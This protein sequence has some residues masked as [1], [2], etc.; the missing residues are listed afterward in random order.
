MNW[1]RLFNSYVPQRKCSDPLT[2]MA[3][4]ASVVNGISG[5]FSQGSANDTNV[6]LARES[7]EWQSKENQLNRDWQETM[8]NKQ[9]EY[10]TPANQRMLA[11]QGG[12]NPYLLSTKN[13]QSGAGAAGTPAAVGAPNV[14]HVNPINPVGVATDTMSSLLP[15]IQQHQQVESNVQLQ[16]SKEIQ[17]YVQTAIDAYDKLGY[18]GYI[19][20]MD[21]LAPALSQIN[22]TDSRSDIMFSEMLKNN[23]SQRYNLDMDSLNKEVEYNLGKKYGEQRIQ[24]NLEKLQYDISE[25]VGRLA[26]MRIQN[27][28]LIQQ[29]AAD[30]VVKGAHAFMLKQEGNKFAADAE[31]ANQLRQYLT[32]SAKHESDML[33][34]DSMFKQADWDS[35][36]E[37]IGFLTGSDGRARIRQAAQIDLEERSGRLMRAMDKVFGEYINVGTN[38]SRGDMNVR[39]T[40]FSQHENVTPI[41]PWTRVTGF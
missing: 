29:T 20:V 10:N 21:T 15:I 34:I 36:T 13:L 1:N 3:I 23:L 30:L 40:G 16:K 14:A 32:K 19:E 2:A 26:T 7:R 35:S 27:D 17:S 9:N 37:K 38:Y 12:Y 18:K 28:A 6:M 8:W 11:E 22:L 4:G 24:A 31:T 25:I 33:A 5:L 41:A 39:S